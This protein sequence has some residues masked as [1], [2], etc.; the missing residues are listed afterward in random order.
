MT[1]YSFFSNTAILQILPTD[2][3]VRVFLPAFNSNVR[4]RDRC[5]HSRG[6][7]LLLIID[8][9]A[10]HVSAES[11]AKRELWTSA[12][13]TTSENLNDEGWSAPRRQNRRGVG[14]IR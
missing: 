10:A 4:V 7:E 6:S 9:G 8:G 13:E 2:V 14:E 3:R 1:Q 11:V 12:S 5:G